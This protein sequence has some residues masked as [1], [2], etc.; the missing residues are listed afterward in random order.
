MILFDH[1]SYSSYRGCLLINHLYSK[2]DDAAEDLYN[3][4]VWLHEIH[5]YHHEQ[6]LTFG[7]DTLSSQY[8]QNYTGGKNQEVSFFLG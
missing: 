1:T 2:I 4:T 3:L 7:R 6:Q 5:W 8:P